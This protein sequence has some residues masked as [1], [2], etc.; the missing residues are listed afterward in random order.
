MFTRIT[1]NGDTAVRRAIS[2]QRVAVGRAV[3]DSITQVM[4]QAG[5]VARPRGQVD[6]MLRAAPIPEH[7]PPV[8]A[9][10]VSTD[11]ATWLR[12]QGRSTG[13]WLVLDAAGGARKAAVD[14]PLN[15]RILAASATHVWGIEHDNADVPGL[16][17]YRID[18]AGSNERVPRFA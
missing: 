14:G 9:M 17:R 16:V 8:S 11:G 7:Y 15:L 4:S 6:A 10:T 2:Y 12:L 13:P 5:G 18:R 3:R 1:I